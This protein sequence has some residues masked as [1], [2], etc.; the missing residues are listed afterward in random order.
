MPECVVARGDRLSSH[1]ELCEHV[2]QNFSCR[3]IVIHHQHPDR[4]QA[5]NQAPL[6]LQCCP[7]PKPACE[8]KG[9]SVPIVTFHPDVAAHHFHQTFGDGEAEPRPA[10]FS[11]CGAI[12]LTEGLEQAH[13]LL[14]GYSN[15]TVADC[16]LQFDP[17]GHALFGLD[18]HYDFTVFRKFHSVVYEVDQHL[19]K[20]E[21]IPNQSRWQVLLNRDKE[22][23]ILLLNSLA[24]DRGQIFKHII[25]AEFRVLEIQLPSFDL[26]EVKYVVDDTEQR[27]AR[28][29]R[30]GKVIALLLS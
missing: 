1:G 22:L 15:A 19:P 23:Q 3:G 20:T 13:D 30:L 21:G 27:L 9:A 17:V 6:S 8:A 18:C 5:K 12:G 26:R 25:Q 29:L 11:S 28:P 4:R 16:K 24:D 7:N 2:T 10:V 14:R